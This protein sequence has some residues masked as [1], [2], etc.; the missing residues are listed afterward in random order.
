VQELLHRSDITVCTQENIESLPLSVSAPIQIAPV[1]FERDLRFVDA[2]E[3]P[4][5]RAERGHRFSNS[6]TSRCT[7]R[8][9]VVCATARLRSAIMW[10]RSRELSLYGTYQRTHRMISS[11]SKCRPLKSAANGAKRSVMPQG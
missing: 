11:W 8:R 9:M 5:C 10:A 7:Q 6:G 3:E 1:A 2:Q 4:T